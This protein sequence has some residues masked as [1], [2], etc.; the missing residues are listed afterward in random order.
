MSH[1]N[2]E[3]LYFSLDKS[4]DPLIV[5]GMFGTKALNGSFSASATTATIT[6]TDSLS[7]KQDIPPHVASQDINVVNHNA[8][9]HAYIASR[10]V[11]GIMTQTTTMKLDADCDKLSL[12]PYHEQLLATT[13]V[14]IRPPKAPRTFSAKL[15]E[16]I[17]DMESVLQDF[18]PKAKSLILFLGSSSYTQCM[19]QILEHLEA[20]ELVYSATASSN[21][22]DL[23]LSVI[24]SLPYLVNLRELTVPGN[25]MSPEV[26][27]ALGDLKNLQRFTVTDNPHIPSQTTRWTSQVSHAWRSI[28][29]H[30]PMLWAA[31][32]DFGD[33]L[34]WI[35][36]V[37]SRA[38]SVPFTDVVLPSL[39]THL[40]SKEYTNSL[41]RSAL[42]NE[43]RS[44]PEI[45]YLL[46]A[47]TLNEEKLAWAMPYLPRC[48]RFF[49]KFKKNLWF[50]IRENVSQP[51]PY[52]H[53]FSI[54]IQGS[55]QTDKDF[56]LPKDIFANR[57][58]QLRVLDIRGC[59]CHFSSPV[60]R[61]LTT[62]IV[63]KPSSSYIPTAVAWLEILGNMKDLHTLVLA[64]AFAP[65]PR[66]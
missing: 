61:N 46:G 15:V 33:R 65:P 32:L 62:L 56:T 50:H 55:Q 37:A 41:M 35:K 5:F 54:I 45:L 21:T 17:V 51:S 25:M 31:S 28:M 14:E 3:T 26:F 47:G 58:P 2:A 43:P 40:M 24:H 18:F 11:A 20:L 7:E 64:S 9:I 8:S 44:I 27:F 59:G 19:M 29:L 12:K 63:R 48:Q 16:F 22:N 52:L 49:V 10:R 1:N 23:Q 34:P 13:V 39:T 53:T 42:R 60:F 66:K 4:S 36:E 57:A 30:Y 38:G 6:V